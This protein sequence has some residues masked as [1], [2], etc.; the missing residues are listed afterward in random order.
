MSPEATTNQRGAGCNAPKETAAPPASTL[1]AIPLRCFPRSG[2]PEAGAPDLSP[3]SGQKRPRPSTPGRPLEAKPKTSQTLPSASA[4]HPAPDLLLSATDGATALTAAVAH[5]PLLAA[6]AI[7]RGLTGPR[8]RPSLAQACLPLRPWSPS[9][10]RSR[11]GSC[12]RSGRTSV[13]STG[14]ACATPNCCPRHSSRSSFTRKAATSSVDSRS[15]TLSLPPHLRLLT[16][17]SA[18]GWSRLLPACSRL[19]PDCKREQ[20]C[21]WLK[22]EMQSETK[23]VE[24]SGNHV[25]IMQSYVKSMNSCKKIT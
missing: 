13:R 21:G 19:M 23:A 16:H 12:S 15:T 20:V 14:R 8:T 9:S 5:P 1:D 17:I 4:A 25:K 7:T 18:M 10:R 11:R 3:P 2:P 24:I 6:R 22:P